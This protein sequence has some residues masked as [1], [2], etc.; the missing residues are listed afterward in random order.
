[1]PAV[2]CMHLADYGVTWKQHTEKLLARRLRLPSGTANATTVPL[3]YL[4][5]H[6]LLHH[7]PPA[8][9]TLV[10][11]QTL[12]SCTPTLCSDLGALPSKHGKLSEA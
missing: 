10:S 3:E 8:R 12:E 4:S 2:S 11:S 6:K 9:T 7:R 5:R 1:M